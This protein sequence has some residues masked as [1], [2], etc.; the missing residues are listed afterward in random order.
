MNSLGTHRHRHH[1]SLSHALRPFAPWCPQVAAKV[2]Y[3]SRI[4]PPFEGEV[5]ADDGMDMEGEGDLDMAVEGE[6]ERVKPPQQN[7]RGRTIIDR[8]A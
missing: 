5:C 3:S 7:Q 4:P 6:R 8:G 1:H 2:S